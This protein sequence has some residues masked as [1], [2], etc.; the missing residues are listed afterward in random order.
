MFNGV[1]LQLSFFLGI[2]IPQL[3]YV[4]HDGMPASLDDYM[5]E[6]GWV[7]RDG[8]QNHAIVHKDSN[9]GPHLSHEV[10]SYAGTAVCLR[11]KLMDYFGDTPTYNT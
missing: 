1:K 7:G 5:Q 6:S 4:I 10:K 2:D 3:H 9:K 11:M 8:V